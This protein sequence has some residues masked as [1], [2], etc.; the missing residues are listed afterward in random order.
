MKI[1]LSMAHGDIEFSGSESMAVDAAINYLH[2]VWLQNAEN[3]YV[4]LETDPDTHSAAVVAIEQAFWRNNLGN[5]F[6]IGTR[7]GQE[8]RIEVWTADS[9]TKLVSLLKSIGW[10]TISATVTT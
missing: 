10:D 5:G 8:V 9:L 4:D 7:G 6:Y 1:L 3:F 2:K